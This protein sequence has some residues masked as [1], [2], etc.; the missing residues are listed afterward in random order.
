MTNLP[1]INPPSAQYADYKQCWNYYIITFLSGLAIGYIL[2]ILRV[3]HDD[4]RRAEDVQRAKDAELKNARIAFQSAFAELRSKCNGGALMTYDLA[5][6]FA[7]VHE[8]AITEFRHHVGQADL[9]SFDAACE[10]YRKCRY[11]ERTPSQQLGPFFT[12]SQTEALAKAIDGLLAF[13]DKT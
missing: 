13:A 3:R 11:P 12:P 7:G 2:H 8:R 10:N 5:G 1:P 9:A 4:K 6:S